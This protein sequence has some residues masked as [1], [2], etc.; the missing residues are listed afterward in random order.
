MTIDKIIELK[1]NLELQKYVRSLEFDK[2]SCCSFYGSPKKHP[3]EQNR[4]ILVADPFSEHTFYYDFNVED[5]LSL[6]EQPSITSMEGESVSMVRLWVKK[7]SIGLQCTP[8][9]VGNVSKMG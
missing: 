7:K 3:H 4:V 1:D 8:F 6:E 9:I 5:I 2:K